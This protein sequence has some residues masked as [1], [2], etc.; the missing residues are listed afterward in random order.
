M[1][2]SVG[3]PPHTRGTRL[4]PVGQSERRRITPAHAGNTSTA[5]DF[6]DLFQDH[7]RTRG[8]HSRWIQTFGPDLG[9]P[10]HTRGTPLQTSYG[11][12][13]A[14]ITPAH[15]GNTQRL[16]GSGQ[17]IR[18]HP[19]T[20]GEHTKISLINQGFCSFFEHNFINFSYN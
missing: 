16:V 18:D 3:S 14:G 1:G 13:A 17:G 10:P 11:T 7:P 4:T 2:Y 12:L 8:E 15:A 5:C 19:R 9:S 6:G 20:R